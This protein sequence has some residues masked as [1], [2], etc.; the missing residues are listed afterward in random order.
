MA[1]GNG[2][3]VFHWNGVLT[4]VGVGNGNGVTVVPGDVGASVGDGP[5]VGVGWFVGV[6][7]GVAVG[8][9]SP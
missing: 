4:A 1:V 9:E 5:T 3:V 6:N 7:I 2:V 8:G